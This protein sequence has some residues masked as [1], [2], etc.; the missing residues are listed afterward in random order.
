MSKNGFWVIARLPQR[1]KSTL[2]FENFS[3][4]S[5]PFGLLRSK[6]FQTMLILALE[7]N[8][9][10]SHKNETKIVKITHSDLVGTYWVGCALLEIFCFHRILGKKHNGKGS[11]W[12]STTIHI[13]HIE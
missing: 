12:I 4:S 7:A 9:A 10:L 5:G 8:S 2:L 3:H 6:K 1:L 13:H 11:R